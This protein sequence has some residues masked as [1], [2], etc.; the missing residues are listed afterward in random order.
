MLYSFC[1]TSLHTINSYEGNS[2]APGY[3]QPSSGVQSG[4]GYGSSGGQTGGYGGSGC[5]QQPS[6]HGGGHYNQPT[7]YNS[8]S[9][10]Y[11]Q[12]SQY[13]QGGG[14]ECVYFKYLFSM[15][16]VRDKFVRYNNSQTL[17]EL[18][19]D[20]RSSGNSLF[21]SMF[22]QDMEMIAHHWV[23]EEGDMV[24]LMEV[25]EVKM[26]VV[27]EGVA[28]DLEVVVAVYMIVVL[29]EVAEVDQ[30]EEEAWG[31]CY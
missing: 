1:N 5:H 19:F 21:N 12:Q 27:A 24:V 16:S 8:P 22:S 3:N 9:Q 29:T 10:S 7:S 2:Q 17:T 14:E 15:N 6:Q 23:Q 31:K 11:S 25:M 4:G 20:C 18:H 26:A 13:S 28:V 30:E